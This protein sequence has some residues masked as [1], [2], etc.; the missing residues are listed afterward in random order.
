MRAYM[1][2]NRRRW[3]E[4]TTLHLT[5]ANGFYGTERLRAGADVLCPI[6]SREI[7]NVAGLSV[8]H[9]QCHFGLDTLSL[10]RRGG[11]VV[12]V[13][14]SETAIAAARALS[15]ETGVAG[16]FIESDLYD[17]PDHPDL[18]GR[19][20]DLVYVTW[21]AINWL[22]DIAGWARVVGHFLKQGGRLYLL[23]THPAALMLEEGAEGALSPTYPYFQGD[24]PLTFDEKTTYT[25]DERVLE[26]SASYEWIHPLAAIF[27][28]LSEAGMAVEYLH[29]FD[30]LPY[31]LYPCMTEN[32]DGM[33][34]LPEATP[35]IPLAFS[36]SAVK[37]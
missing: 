25:G 9:L 15:E 34:V 30:A 23:E 26:N 32:G 24:E 2:A 10:A 6:E 12:G 28:G 31:K 33:Y 5:C 3:N 20:F 27:S 36:I 18:R 16:A 11:D 4:A 17:A 1:E 37:R 21:G 7:G 8:L 29:E 35:S 19:S 13:D 22:P 14:F